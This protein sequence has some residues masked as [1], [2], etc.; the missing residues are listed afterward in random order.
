MD[1]VQLSLRG[2][3]LLITTQFPKI[4]GTHLV[5]LGSMKG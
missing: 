3:S 1:V 4:M 5:N 2:G